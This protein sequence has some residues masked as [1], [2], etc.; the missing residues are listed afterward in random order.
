MSDNDHWRIISTIPR[1]RII[2]IKSV[3]G[4]ECWAKV[5]GNAQVKVQKHTGK[6][7]IACWR[8]GGRPSGS[9]DVNAIAW[10]EIED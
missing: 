10:K 3:S 4:I 2:M 7:T 6:L 9:G 5:A 8:K 1:D